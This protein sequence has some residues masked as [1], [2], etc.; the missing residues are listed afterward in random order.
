MQAAQAAG[1]YIP[2]LCHHAD[3]AP[4]G[5]CKVCSVRIQGRIRLACQ[6][7]CADGMAIDTDAGTAPGSATPCP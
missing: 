4:I 2:H 6:T 1:A 3:F 7:V 5:S